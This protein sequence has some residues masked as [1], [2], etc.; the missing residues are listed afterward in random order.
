MKQRSGTPTDAPAIARLIQ[1]FASDFTVNPNAQ[2][3]EKYFESVSERA[4]REYLSSERYK[5]VL[6]VDEDALLGFVAMRD[7]THLFHLFVEP[8]HHRQ[9]IAR[10]LWNQVHREAREQGHSTYTVNSSLRA[11]P[12][13]KAFGFVTSGLKAEAHGISFQPMY[14]GARPNEA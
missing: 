14:L 10:N 13:Y 12:V 1:C 8:G 11:I 6:A 9:G 2:G 7:N 3:A 4:E 5:F